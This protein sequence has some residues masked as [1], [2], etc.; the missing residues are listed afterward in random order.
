MLDKVTLIIDGNY[1]CWRAYFAVG[2]LRHNDISTGVIFGFFSQ[3]KSMLST[4][5]PANPI[6]A[7]D[8]AKNIRKQEC[9]HYKER[10]DNP[11]DEEQQARMITIEQAK[12]L[13]R[14]ALPQ[15]GINNNYRLTGFEADDIIAKFVMTFDG[16]HVVVS[17]DDDLLQLLDYC[18]I[19]NP[20]HETTTNGMTFR[21]QNGLSPAQFAQIK[22]IAGCD[23]DNVK[24]VPTVGEKTAEK[25]V[26]GDL[27]T[28]YKTYQKIVENHNT[29]IETANLVQ[30]PHKKCPELS[31]PAQN[32]FSKDGFKTVCDEYGLQSMIEDVDEWEELIV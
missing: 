23:T 3:L 9:S 7:W 19:Y 8:S 24:G 6:I 16:P 14:W 15:I 17:G 22:A 10:N 27:P 30:L 11:S 12:D 20:N 28:H 31:T 2:D 1:L 29:I 5:Y 18:S 32:K 21:K 4:H 26:K 25:Y 13:Q